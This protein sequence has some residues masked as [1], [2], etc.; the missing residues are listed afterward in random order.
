MGSFSP[1]PVLPDTNW[2]RRQMWGYF[3]AI[4]PGLFVIGCH[5]KICFFVK[6]STLQLASLPLS[7]KLISQPTKLNFYA[8]LSERTFCCQRLFMTG[9]GFDNKSSKGRSCPSKFHLCSRSCNYNFRWGHAKSRR[10]KMLW[11]LS[12]GLNIL[13][14]RAPRENWIVYNKTRAG[15]VEKPAFVILL[16]SW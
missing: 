5:N 13:G 11:A 7:S 2:L 9:S 4:A 15:G 6:T 3:L 16:Q 1:S 10:T 8:C 14:H 12:S